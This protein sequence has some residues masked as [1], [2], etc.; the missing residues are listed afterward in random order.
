M[1]HVKRVFTLCAI[2]LSI[3]S[4]AIA[5]NGFTLRA[6]GNFP[7]G[8]F[9]KGERMSDLALSKDNATFGGAGIGFNAGIK[10]Q[11]GLIGDLSAFATADLFYNGLNNDIKEAYADAEESATL[12]A[13][14]NTP[15]MAGIHYTLLDLLG[16]SLWVE[17]GAG[18][19]FRHITKSAVKA[20]IGD[21]ISGNA[22]TT[23]DT[24]AT[25]AWQAGL[26]VSLSHT[27]TLGVHYYSFGNTPIKGEN[28]VEAG[29]GGISG[30]ITPIEVQNGKLNTSMV[31]VRLGYTF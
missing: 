30:A 4:A 24:G 3:S 12:P 7:V 22:E 14:I 29:V 5:Q 9:G 1:K 18:A 31:S 27:F 26:G 19:N 16:L 2:I 11:L 25:F 28:S 15:L 13:Y 20:T 6:G 17:A 8:A 23:Y 21:F 10:Y